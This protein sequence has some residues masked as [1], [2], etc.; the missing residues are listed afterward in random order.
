MAPPGF[1]SSGSEVRREAGGAP[2]SALYESDHDAQ[3][4]AV[5][6]G[7]RD[8]QE[9]CQS[10][11]AI[12]CR[13]IPAVEGGLVLTVLNLDALDQAFD[14]TADVDGLTRFDQAIELFGVHRNR[15]E[16]CEQ[17]AQRTIHEPIDDREEPALRRAGEAGG[18]TPLEYSMSFRCNGPD[19]GTW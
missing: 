4:W 5:L 19:G 14:R 18:G 6:A 10:W 11:L 2:G 8:A 13:L 16:K 15:H 9:F 17:A 3:L 1:E 12:Q 7:T